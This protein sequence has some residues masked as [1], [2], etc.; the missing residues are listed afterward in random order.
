MCLPENSR[1]SLPKKKKEKKK[2][3]I[4]RHWRRVQLVCRYA[5]KESMFREV[6][7]ATVSLRIRSLSKQF[8]FWSIL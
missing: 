4:H 7:T 3:S 1:G 2:G 8:S 5:N 6:L